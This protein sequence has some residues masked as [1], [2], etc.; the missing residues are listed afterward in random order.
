MT[1]IL[2]SRMHGEIWLSADKR[3]NLGTLHHDTVRKIWRA[4]AFAF[5]MAGSLAQWQLLQ[6]VLEAQRTTMVRKSKDAK[7]GKLN[8][9]AFCSD[10]ERKYRVL[11]SESGVLQ[12]VQAEDGTSLMCSGLTFMSV[13]G[14]S[15]CL[16]L[17]YGETVS[18][19]DQFVAVG[20]GADL[21]IGYMSAIAAI[22]NTQPAD[23]R[24]LETSG[25]HCVA[26]AH[27]FVA[28]RD[29]SCSPE[30]DLTII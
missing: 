4:G 28:Y 10:I 20:S 27:H 15:I 22:D 24:L 26:Q 9:I 7:S 3:V 21:I 19:N 30:Y 23:K 14:S 5:G 18:V 11:G 8:P 13:I 2:A 1:V 25:V 16:T 29:K 17:S 6:Q 12:A